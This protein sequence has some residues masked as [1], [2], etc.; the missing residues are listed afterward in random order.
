MSVL[1]QLR[2]LDDGV[3][4]ASP[5]LAPQLCR[6]VQPNAQISQPHTGQVV[7]LQRAGGGGMRA[8]EHKGERARGKVCEREHERGRERERVRGRAREGDEKEGGERES[9]R[10]GAREGG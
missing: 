3:L 2:T 10:E 6:D 4:K 9:K 8:R 7:H 1:H 5:D